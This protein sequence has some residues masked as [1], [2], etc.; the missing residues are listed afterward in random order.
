MGANYQNLSGDI[1]QLRGYINSYSQR[2]SAFNVP[3]TMPFYT[4]HMW[5]CANIFKDQD[6]NRAQTYMFMPGYFHIYNDA[7][8]RLDAELFTSGG[9]TALKTI[10][11]LINFG[12][13]IITNLIGSEDI[14]IMSGDILKAYGSDKMFKLDTIPENYQL[15]PMFSQEV[16]TQINA[17]TMVGNV[18]DPTDLNVQQT[19]TGF[20]YQGK[21]VGPIIEPPKFFN[22]QFSNNLVPGTSI[23]TGN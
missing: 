9:G 3:T 10:S 5:L 20:I 11:Q 17:A 6:L 7:Q 16:L 21:E 15:S 12:N 22:V 13:K 8:G 14:G 2:I 4:R 19:A 1:A 23:K 18:V